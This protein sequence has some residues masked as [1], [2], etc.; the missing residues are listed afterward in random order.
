METRGLDLPQAEREVV[1]DWVGNNLYKSGFAKA[2]VD[3][4]VGVGNAFVRTIDKLRLALGN[5]K[6]RANTNL[7]VVER[8]FMRAL[9]QEQVTREGDVEYA[10]LSTVRKAISNKGDIGEKYNQ[11]KLSPVPAKVAEMVFQASDGAID[12]SNKTIA[13]NGDDI[14]HAHLRH[15]DV[16]KETSRNQIAISEQ[17]IAEMIEAIYAPDVVE[18]LFDDTNNPTQR[19][20][21]AYAKKKGGYYIVAEAVGGSRNPNIVPVQMIYVT[22]AKWNQFIGAGKTIGEMIYEND[23]EKRAALD[24]QK[25]KKNRV[26]AAQF[27]SKKTIANTPRSPQFNTTVAQKPPGVNP[28]S[29]QNGQKNSPKLHCQP[30]LA[31]G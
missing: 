17:D 29:M 6:S 31:G 13:V 12:I 10:I 1:A 30:C 7:A 4:N 14:Y 11:K 2:I 3:G 5:K 15:S 8:L 20:S 24:V 21:F 26:T 19:L 23:A 18:C 9:E 16:E 28:Y 27:V 25:N 22:E